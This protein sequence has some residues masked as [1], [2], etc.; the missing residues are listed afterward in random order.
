MNK[1]LFVKF[2]IKF[3]NLARNPTGD[4]VGNLTY[5]L[6]GDPAHRKHLHA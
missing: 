3:G 1:T 4:L 5:D 2:F 6:A